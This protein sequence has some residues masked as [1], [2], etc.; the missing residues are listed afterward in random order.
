ME[1][2]KGYIYILSNPSMD[3]VLK[4]GMSK[5][6][7]II[8]SNEL[9]ATGVPTPFVIEFDMLV[10]DC[11]GIEVYM[12][13]YLSDF[14]VN[15]SREFFKIDVNHVAN[16][17]IRKLF[18]AA[19]EKPASEIVEQPIVNEEYLAGDALTSISG[20]DG[21]CISTMMICQ[22][23]DFSCAIR[24]ANAV[25]RINID[26]ISIPSRIRKNLIKARRKSIK[27]NYLY[28][29][30][31]ARVNNNETDVTEHFSAIDVYR[32]AKYMHTMPDMNIK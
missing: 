5:R 31:V 19:I 13:S 1:D 10:D 26:G 11:R 14:R 16:E 12:H 24:Y 23:V 22:M 4:V 6:G 32:L 25:D 2:K 21:T 30:D 8:R 9:Y 27:E 15:N 29:R 18:G 3:G 7:A 20:N 28:I 17:I